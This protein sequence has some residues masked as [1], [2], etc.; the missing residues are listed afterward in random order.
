MYEHLPQI[1]LDQA[2]LVASLDLLPI[3]IIMSRCHHLASDILE[4]YHSHF[5]QAITD[6]NLQLN[7]HC[8]LERTATT[9]LLQDAN[10]SLSG[11]FLVAL[12]NEVLSG[13]SCGTEARMG[14]LVSH[15]PFK[16]AHIP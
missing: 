5:L 9:E 14:S 12:A 1:P 7:C 16:R 3:T 4:S 11:A 8:S 10:V 2:L 15:N 6:D 13:L